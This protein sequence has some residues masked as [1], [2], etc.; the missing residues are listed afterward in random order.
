MKNKL[1][2]IIAAILCA[3]LLCG[4]SADQKPAE[5]PADSETAVSSDVSDSGEFTAAPSTVSAESSPAP[6][7]S[8]ISA[9]APTEEF[10][11]ETSTAES[12]VTSDISSETTPAQSTT[13]AAP[14]PVSTAATTVKTTA[15][16]VKTSTA[17]K[18]AELT[19]FSVDW[20]L[21]STWEEGGN[22]CGGYEATLTNNSGSDVG[23][24]TVKV[25]VPS[26]FKLTA[27]WNG[28]FSVSGTTLTI[29]NE[30]YNGSVPSGGNTGFGFNAVEG[31]S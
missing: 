16:T 29:K 17:T 5:I 28:V 9:I 21:N 4:C 12:P 30:S 20:K 6:E 13:G 1:R 3:S 14:E 11:G 25:T 15:S 24:W 26:G 23:S 7:L 27:S 22:K 8:V 19:K 18:P 10:S 31:Y 2:S